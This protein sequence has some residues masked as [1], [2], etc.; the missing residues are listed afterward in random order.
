MIFTNAA[1][2][3]CKS[4]MQLARV[5]SSETAKHCLACVSPS[6]QASL[7]GCMGQQ[8]LEIIKSSVGS[9]CYCMTLWFAGDFAGLQHCKLFT[10]KRSELSD[11]CNC[12][13]AQAH[14]CG[15]LCDASFA[16][17]N[18]KHPR[19]LHSQVSESPCHV[20]RRKM[21]VLVMQVPPLAQCPQM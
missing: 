16:F 18:Y 5:S 10:F 11:S 6:F 8:G 12:D 9:A 17:C 19:C 21:Q 7:H 3:A 20:C 2:S 1:C 14:Q 4:T 13:M 15:G